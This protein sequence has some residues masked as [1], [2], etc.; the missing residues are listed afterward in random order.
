MTVGKAELIWFIKDLDI[1]KFTKY[2]F[3]VCSIWVM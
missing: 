3:T 2:F 1:P